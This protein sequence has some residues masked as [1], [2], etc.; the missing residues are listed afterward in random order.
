MHVRYVCTYACRQL[1][2]GGRELKQTA[3]FELRHGVRTLAG[4]LDRV[5]QKYSVNFIKPANC[6]RTVI[7]TNRMYVRV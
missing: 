1:V 4:W 7:R 3:A 2:G 6:L 5:L